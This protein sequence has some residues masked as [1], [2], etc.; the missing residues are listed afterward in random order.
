MIAPT[1]VEF[2]REG[3]F[4]SLLSGTPKRRGTGQEKKKPKPKAKSSGGGSQEPHRTVV[5]K[6]INGPTRA[7]LYHEAEFCVD[8]DG[9]LIFRTKFTIE[10]DEHIC[11]TVVHACVLS[12]EH[13]GEMPDNFKLAGKIHVMMPALADSKIYPFTGFYNTENRGGNLRVQIPS[14][15]L[16]LP[17]P[18]DD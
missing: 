1:Q 11:N 3:Y 8:R 15:H 18:L 6:I 17:H 7:E 14:I 2:F 10:Q 9:I 12:I 13:A 4:M 5:L 16:G